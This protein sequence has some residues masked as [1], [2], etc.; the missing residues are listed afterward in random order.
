[1]MKRII[2]SHLHL[3][4]IYKDHLN[5]INWLKEK[6]CAVVSWAYFEGIQSVQQLHDALHAKGS[7][8]RKFGQ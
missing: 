7:V 5:H 8:H 6:R 3:D 1:M 2:D 4:M